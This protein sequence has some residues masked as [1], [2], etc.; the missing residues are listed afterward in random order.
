[1][2]AAQPSMH[3]SKHKTHKKDG[4]LNVEIFATSN[5]RDHNIPVNLNLRHQILGVPSFNGVHPHRM[6]FDITS[7]PIRL[8]PRYAEGL[9]QSTGSAT[10]EGGIDEGFGFE[11]SF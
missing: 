2:Q 8:V 10:R 1:M 4:D 9:V 6:E 5:G 11:L 7:T 3:K